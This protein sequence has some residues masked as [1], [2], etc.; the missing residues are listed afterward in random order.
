MQ[1]FSE[2]LKEEF[3]KHGDADIAL[4]QAAYMKNRFAFYGLKSPQ[5]KAIQQPFLAKEFLPDKLTAQNII[6]ELWAAPQ[7]ELQYFA[8]ELAGK[9]RK[10]IE[11]EDIHFYEKLLLQKSWWDTVDFVASTLVGHYFKKY[12]QQ[13][14][15][16]TGAWLSSGNIWLQ[17]SCLIFQL[18]YKKDIDRELMKKFIVR[19]L[20]S[21]EFFIK[22]AIGWILRQYAKFEPDWVLNFV[23]ETPL[24]TLSKKEALKHFAD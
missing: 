13:I 23:N 15:T 11:K 8:M 9:Y 3:R 14:A 2:L 12:P 18:K 21:N 5:R 19:L 20:D 10:G 24:K 4:A 1:D 17:R 16:V 22:K 7:R 6:L